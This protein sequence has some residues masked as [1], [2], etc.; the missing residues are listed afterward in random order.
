MSLAA[1][2]QVL[3][4]FPSLKQLGRNVDPNNLVVAPA[5]LITNRILAGAGVKLNWHR[6]LHFCTDEPGR[7]IQV[8]SSG[9][10]P[11]LRFT[12][13]DLRLIARGLERGADFRLARVN[14]PP[15]VLAALDLE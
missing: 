7:S 6:N 5:E 12:Y 4:R 9:H 8:D 15:V 1:L 14:V 13:T 11:S 3:N 2:A 10:T